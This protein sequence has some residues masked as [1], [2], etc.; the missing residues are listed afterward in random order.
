VIRLDV[1][2]NTPEWENARIGIPTASGFAHIITAAGKPGGQAEKYRNQL[3]AEWW[4]QTPFDWTGSSGFMERGK[5]LEREARAYYQFQHRVKV[6]LGGFCYRDD[7]MAGCSPDGLIGE[8]RGLEIKCP[9][10]PVHIGYLLNPRALAADYHVQVQG[11]L[12]I[13]GL[14]EWD[15]LAYHQDLPPV[16]IRVLPNLQFQIAL[17]RQLDRFISDLL[18]AREQ[19]TALREAR[20]T[21]QAEPARTPTIT[22]DEG[23]LFG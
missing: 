11:S 7:R 12:N 22:P 17:K 13:T 19:L 8:A 1:A 15:L 21:L 16:E 4:Y 5:D 6:Q 23:E 20:T 2:Q 9:S 14:P 18:A 10:L 3:L